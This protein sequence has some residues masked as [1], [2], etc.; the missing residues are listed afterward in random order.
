[1]TCGGQ[2]PLALGFFSSRTLFLSSRPGS[3]TSGFSQLKILVCCLQSWDEGKSL[4][5]GGQQLISFGADVEDGN[6]P[7]GA[8]R[9][10]KD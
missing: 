5:G 7:R 1:M 2:V 6:R 9:E 10:K 8:G 3:V 4:G